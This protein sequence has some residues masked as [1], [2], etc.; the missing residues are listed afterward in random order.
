MGCKIASFLGGFLTV[1]HTLQ[2]FL[3]FFVL[4]SLCALRCL[5]GLSISRL[6]PTSQGFK[7]II[8]I[9]FKHF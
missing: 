9:D 6:F 1:A 3:F 5:L 7:P 8:L 4:F 2:N